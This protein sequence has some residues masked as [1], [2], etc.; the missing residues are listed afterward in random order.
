MFCCISSNFAFGGRSVTLFMDHG[1]MS[2]LMFKLLKA[3]PPPRKVKERMRQMSVPCVVNSAQP[4]QVVVSAKSIIV[5][6]VLMP[7]L[8]GKRS[9]IS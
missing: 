9:F 8:V 2:C 7:T 1:T 6:N 3:T 5:M 4:S